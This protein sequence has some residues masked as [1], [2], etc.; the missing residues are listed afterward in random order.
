MYQIMC[1]YN[2]RYSDRMAIKRSIVVVVTVIMSLLSLMVVAQSQPNTADVL[3]QRYA[4]SVYQV[5]IVDVDSGSQS[6]IGTGFVVADG[7]FLATNYHVISSLIHKPEQ[8]QGEI[9]I[10]G[11]A[12]GLEI[13][14][15][16]VVND[17]AVLKPREPINLGRA[18]SLAGQAPLQGETLYSIGNPHDIGMT[19]VEGNYNGYVEHRFLEL[20]HF[21]GSINPGM[22]GGPAINRQGEVVGIN[23][24]TAGDQI[25]FLVPV[26][27]LNT[28]I[29]QM[30][31][32]NAVDNF[33][34]LS[35]QL[36]QF[37]DTMMQQLLDKPWAMET[38]G[39]AAVVDKISPKMECWGDSDHDEKRGLSYIS[40]G[41]SNKERI[42]VGQRFN[43]GYVEYEFSSYEAK[44]WN[45]TSFYRYIANRNSTARPG[46]RADK[47]SVNNYQ[48]Y[49]DIVGDTPESMKRK[50][51]YCVRSYKK[52]KQLYDVF[53][54]GASIDRE[55]TI[56]THHYTL[57]G[58]SK[59]LAE[60]FLARFMESIRWQ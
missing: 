53:Y 26:K 54:L 7:Q 3:Y 56:V 35:Q 34:R 23:V 60:K 42:F 46:N 43:V 32:I 57:S 55:H 40:K 10:D 36:A 58:V 33:E 2:R 24:A 21:S 17:L 28:L 22:S 37:S 47:D 13:V 31:D 14:S 11:T 45:S 48:C 52:I 27:K 19:V 50:V 39:D 1:E 15:F 44:K 4:D 16:D 5:R 51:S 38:M 9:A 8:Y 30:A 49:N 59:H 18:L 29:T 41:C 12:Y 6:A 25:G 20:I